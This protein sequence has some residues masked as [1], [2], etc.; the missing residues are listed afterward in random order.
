MKS[1]V[2]EGEKRIIYI[3]KEKPSPNGGAVAKVQYASIC[4]TD[5]RSYRFGNSKLD[6]RR[7]VGHEACMVIESADKK[8][9]DYQVGERIMVAPAIGCGE[10]LSC[11]R[12]HTNM[13]ENLKTI[14]FEYDGTFSEYCYIP[15]QAFKMNNVIRVPDNVSSVSAC[16]A[17]PVA[18]A[19]NGQ[20]FLKIQRGENVLIFGAGY[21]GCI[22]AE[23]ALLSGADKVIIA[24]PS[25][26]RRNQASK[27]LPD[28]IVLDSSSDDFIDT[29]RDAGGKNGIDVAITACPA[30]VTHTQAQIII[31]SEGRI[32]LFGGL[33]GVSSG[34]LD[35]NLI[36][37]KELS[38]FGVHA[39]TPD[40]NRKALE[41]ISGGRLKVEKYVDIF[42]LKDADSAFNSL[43]SEQS[44]KAV[45]S[46]MQSE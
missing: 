23:L 10:C 18:C 4:G 35:S 2:Y 39:S 12:G 14:G 45:L 25:E 16:V 42:E 34:F 43:L 41:L 19:I 22:H 20:S 32:S 28:I 3:D 26:K 46:I 6:F 7:T 33:A 40:H 29:A 9:T 36:H 44:V 27:Y 31:N 17:E 38:I 1:C 5:L 11:R 8:I 37:Y 30:G 24:E 21:L 13:C 15:Q